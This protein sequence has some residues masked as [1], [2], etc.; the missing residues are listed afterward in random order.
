MKQN[1]IRQKTLFDDENSDS[2]YFKEEIKRIH[3]QEI[4]E[5]EKAYMKKYAKRVQVPLSEVDKTIER[6]MK[7]YEE[8]LKDIYGGTIPNDKKSYSDM[9]KEI[10]RDFISD[11]D[12]EF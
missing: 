7:A 11:A 6:N 3:Q 8:M 9:V 1:I 5:K 4:K 12:Y 10:V 2:N